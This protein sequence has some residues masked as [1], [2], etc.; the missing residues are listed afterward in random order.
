MIRT[1]SLQAQSDRLET[2]RG[3]LAA[4]VGMDTAFLPYF[5]LIEAELER[6]DVNS[7]AVN[8][9]KEIAARQRATR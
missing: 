2:A 4:L 9:A 6:M 8:R 7:L 3:V 5:Q 1:T